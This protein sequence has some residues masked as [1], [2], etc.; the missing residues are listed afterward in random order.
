MAA[1]FELFAHNT[2]MCL[3]SIPVLTRSESEISE[4]PC[5]F[6]IIFGGIWNYID[7]KTSSSR[8]VQTIWN[9]CAFICPIFLKGVSHEF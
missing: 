3:K 2:A 8:I 9:G 1:L 6:L 4:T 5:F 7:T